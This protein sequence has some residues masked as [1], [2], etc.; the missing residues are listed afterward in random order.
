MS[1]FKLP[2]QGTL[3]EQE[4]AVRAATQAPSLRRRLAAFTYEGVLL[5]GLV[6]AVGALY[7]VIANQRHGLQGREGMMA[8]QF[9][10][11]S[12]YFLWFWTHGGQTLATKTWHLRIVSPDGQAIGLKQ[13]LMRYMLSWL[14]LMP[15]WAGAWLAGWHQSK[16]LFGAMGV[17]ILLYAALSFLLPQRQ[18][19]HDVLSGTR[20][21]DTRP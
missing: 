3:S 17:W 20:L 8:S 19:L 4:V 9:L 18:F 10:A 12:L 11:L 15:P 13:A 6:M 2:A 14:W 7:S 1:I 16:E 5:F 21:V